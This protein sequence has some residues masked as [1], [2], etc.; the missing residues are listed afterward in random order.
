MR[1]NGQR[2]KPIARFLRI[3]R[4]GPCLPWCRLD[5]QRYCGAGLGSSW[6][7]PE[8]LERVN[9]FRCSTADLPTQSALR[10]RPQGSRCALS[11][12]VTLNSQSS[13]E[14]RG[15]PIHL[16]DRVSAA[17]RRAEAVR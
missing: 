2:R 9:V 3:E 8:E 15:A 7:K 16:R 4:T 14:P 13:A 10:I 5:D 12:P 6:V 1:S 11:R 17:A